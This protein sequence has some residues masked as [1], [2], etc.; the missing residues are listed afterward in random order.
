MC[1]RDSCQTASSSCGWDAL[2]S[3][4]LPTPCPSGYVRAVDGQSC[5]STDYSGPSESDWDKIRNDPPPAQVMKELC[6]NLSK[7]GS[8]SYACPVSNQQAT[9]TTEPL[10]EWKTDPLT[11]NQSRQVVK[12]LPA[13]TTSNPER[14]EINIDIETKTTTTNP[15]TGQPETTTE[16][17]NLSLIHI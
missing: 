14:V 7:L 9:A 1:I 8:T 3:Q 6:Q 11:G 10:S 17:K 5:L 2:Y 15:E 12:I 13:P 16:T 4:A